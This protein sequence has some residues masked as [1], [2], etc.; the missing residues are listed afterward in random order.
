[1]SPHPSESDEEINVHDDESDAEVTNN[2]SHVAYKKPLELTKHD[3]NWGEAETEAYLMFAQMKEKQV[4]IKFAL[5]NSTQF[6]FENIFVWRDLFV[7]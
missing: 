6:S 4:F 7:T 1:M 3:R 5:T 2:N